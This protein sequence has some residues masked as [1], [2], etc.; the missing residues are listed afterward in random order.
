MKDIRDIEREL[1]RGLC[2][3][4]QYVCAL[5]DDGPVWLWEEIG[6]AR[7][8]E[9]LHLKY[10]PIWCALVALTPWWPVEKDKLQPEFQ[11][12]LSLLPPRIINHNESSLEKVCA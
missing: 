2:R 11:S 8:P 9:H 12:N 10:D 3:I 4:M 1:D 7:L 5:G 6:Q